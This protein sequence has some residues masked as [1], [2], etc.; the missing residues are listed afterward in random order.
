MPG[1][2]SPNDR[3]LGSNA[4]AVLAQLRLWP[5]IQL[6]AQSEAV[7]DVVFH[8]RTIATIESDRE[9]AEIA[10]TAVDADQVLRDHPDAEPGLSGITVHLTSPSHVK[11]ALALICQGRDE[12]LY[13]WQLSAS[14]P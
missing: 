9:I 6:E 5:Q 13:H 10:G 1:G 4:A 8:T 12:V 14:G 2:T 3:A 7:T 11:T